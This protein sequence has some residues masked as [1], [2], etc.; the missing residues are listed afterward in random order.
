[1]PFCLSAVLR[2]TVHLY[3]SS[4]KAQ[5]EEPVLCDPLLE[6]LKPIARV[7]D[8]PK[9]FSVFEPFIVIQ[10]LEPI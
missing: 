8:I 9:E 3:Q 1:M 6:G 7:I 2:L 5:R 4:F 10:T